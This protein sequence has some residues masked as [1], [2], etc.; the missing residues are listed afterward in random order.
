MAYEN[1]IFE[2][3]GNVA[4]IKFNRPKAL[5]A[6][7]PDVLVEVNDALDSIESDPDTKVL[8]L[9]GRG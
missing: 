1:I 8:I 6:I 2:K 7:N 5:N 9:T 3:D 4:V